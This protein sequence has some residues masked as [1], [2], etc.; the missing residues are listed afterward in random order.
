MQRLPPPHHFVLH[1]HTNNSNDTHI[2]FIGFTGI[3]NDAR[4]LLQHSHIISIC[5]NLS[6]VAIGQR[7]SPSQITHISQLN[8]SGSSQAGNT[9]SIP[10]L[11]DRDHQMITILQI[12]RTK[13]QALFILVLPLHLSLQS[14]SSGLNK[15]TL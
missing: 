4:P 5:H 10:S 8:N 2:F 9:I 6:Y 11:A 7:P 12:S 3:H 13:T 14:S 15:A 1:F